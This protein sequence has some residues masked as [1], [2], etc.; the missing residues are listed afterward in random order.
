MRGT[1]PA[2]VSIDRLDVDNRSVDRLK[3]DEIE[4]FAFDL[5]DLRAEFRKRGVD[6]RISTDLQVGRWWSPLNSFESCA[7]V[8]A[9]AVMPTIAGVCLLLLPTDERLWIRSFPGSCEQCGYDLRGQLDG[10]CPEC[11]WRRPSVGD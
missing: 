4:A 10:G 7:I 6:D 8:F 5:R 1:R 2:W 11:G 3:P 9:I